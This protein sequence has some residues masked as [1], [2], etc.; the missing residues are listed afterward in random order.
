[1]HVYKIVVVKKYTYTGLEVE[2]SKDPSLVSASLYKIVVVKK[3]TYTGLE[4]EPS[5]D[6][7]LVSACL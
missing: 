6:P 1:M 5:K 2:P 7:S 4:V 3:Y